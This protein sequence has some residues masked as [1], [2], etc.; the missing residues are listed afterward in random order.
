MKK[1][2][3][4]TLAE[5]LVTMAIIGVIAAI[6]FP[7]LNNAQPNK[8]MVLTKKAYYNVGRIIGE[9]I[10]DEDFYPDTDSDE[11]TRRGFGHVFIADVR[12][13][14]QEAIYHGVRYSGNS[15]F[16]GLFGTKLNLINNGDGNLNTLCNARKTLDEGGNYVTT[17]GIM[18]SMPVGDFSSES[19]EEEIDVDLNG[20]K[21]PNCTRGDALA[22][23]TAACEKGVAPDRFA[24]RVHRE[25]A[26]KIPSELGRLYVTSTRVNQHYQDFV[27]FHP[28]IEPADEKAD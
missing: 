1:R 2:Y 23:G 25:G 20:Y 8:E 3:G 13:Q 22:D 27:R 15:K 11:A 14:G 28:D 5:T 7:V 12:G 26:L 10:N 21:R 6:L 16:C 18:W 24:F 9:L 17:D 4:F 19:G